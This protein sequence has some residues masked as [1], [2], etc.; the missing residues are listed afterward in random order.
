MKVRVLKILNIYFYISNKKGV[1]C[2]GKLISG[3]TH[4]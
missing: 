1:Q 2:L 3:K 4:S